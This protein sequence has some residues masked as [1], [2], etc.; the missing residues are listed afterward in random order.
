MLA[1]LISTISYIVVIWV[2]GTVLVKDAT[3]SFA[4][5]AT[6][7]SVGNLTSVATAAVQNSTSAPTIQYTF[8]NIQNC[9]LAPEGE[10]RYGLMNDYQVCFI[11]GQ[12][13]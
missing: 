13:K 7:M 10:C 5:I 1:I 12:I 11:K 6:Q 3:G 9:S 2:L 4:V 8:T